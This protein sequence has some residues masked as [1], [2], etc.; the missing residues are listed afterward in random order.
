MSTARGVGDVHGL[1]LWLTSTC[2]LSVEAASN[3]VREFRAS[4]R[5]V[6][7]VICWRADDECAREELGLLIDL[8]QAEVRC[9]VVTAAV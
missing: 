2:G 1:E 4:D 3:F 6:R 7:N 8:P 9:C 5:W